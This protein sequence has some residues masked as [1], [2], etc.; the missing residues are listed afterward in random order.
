MK[1]K[2]RLKSLP[3]AVYFVHKDTKRWKDLM[4]D[5]IPP[6]TELLIE[7]FRD[8][9]DSWTLQT[10][11]QLKRRGLEV[12]L[13]PNY[14]PGNIC[15]TSYEDLAIRDLPFNSYVIACRHDRG[16]PEI[17]EQRVVQNY[18][19]I[20]DSTDHFLPHW[21][22]P[23]L[24]P[25]KKKRGTMIKN[26]VFKG[27][28]RNF[29]T[30]LKNPQFIKQLSSL[31][32]NLLV[33]LDEA[34]DGYINWGDYTESDV[35]LAARNCTE[36]D[37]SNKPPTKLVNAWLAGSPALLGPEPAYQNLRVSELDY[38]E[39]R[40]PNDV[41]SALVRLRD[42]PNLY[43]AMVENGFRRAEEFTPDRIALLW[44]DLLA[45]PIREGYEQWLRQSPIQK[46]VGRSAQFAWRAIQHKRERQH[47]L[48]NIH[49]GSR[50]FPVLDP[51]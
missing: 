46:I 20:V 44:R 19:N 10:F 43:T 16:R 8:A 32:F 47:F 6:S 24:Q 30:E 48:V 31:G 3:R 39:I 51:S 49:Q 21:P 23:N 22:Q 35:I 41:I 26:V 5:D 28:K 42:N 7:R 17:C 50:L 38:I 13:V 12:H 45:G 18:L 34:K 25:R 4:N 15:V 11:V 14:I 37:L 40:S 36:Y 2:E 33:G 27:R 1:E 29:A 9:N